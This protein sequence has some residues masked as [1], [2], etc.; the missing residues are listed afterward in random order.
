MFGLGFGLDLLD[1]RLFK[2]QRPAL[3]RSRSLIRGI[4]EVLP[5]APPREDFL[6]ICEV[7]EG[8]ATQVMLAKKHAFVTV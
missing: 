3:S 2:V 8:S 5:L 4:E 7:G 1:E 6:E